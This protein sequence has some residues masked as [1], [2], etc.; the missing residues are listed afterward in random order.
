MTI[1]VDDASVH[2]TVTD[3]STGRRY[4]SHCYG[5]RRRLSVGLT[6]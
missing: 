1:Y 5:V 2:A 6:R 4:T 3:T